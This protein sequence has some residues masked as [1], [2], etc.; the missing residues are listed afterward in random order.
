MPKEYV[1]LKKYLL[2]NN[3]AEQMAKITKQILILASGWRNS[4]VHKLT[5]TCMEA[6]A[7]SG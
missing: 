5:T 3:T 7:S 1:C 2:T 4:W 6:L